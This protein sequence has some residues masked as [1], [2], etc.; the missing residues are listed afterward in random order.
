M[1]EFIERLGA[2]GRRITSDFLV[3]PQNAV[4]LIDADEKRYVRAIDGLAVEDTW[5]YGKGRAKWNNPKAGDLS[6]TAEDPDWT[7]PNRIEQ[8]GKFMKHDLPVFSVDYCV[9]EE[10]AARVYRE[11]RAGGLRPLVTR[12]SLSKV[13]VTPPEK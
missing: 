5:Y 13:T 6:H 11:A 2:A 1:I 10:N 4:E 9:N 8:Y 7:P 12:V 3:V